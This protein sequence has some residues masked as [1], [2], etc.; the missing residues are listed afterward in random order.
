MLAKKSAFDILMNR[1]NRQKNESPQAN[2]NNATTAEKKNE[3]AT[4]TDEII[5]LVNETIILDQND[6]DI[7]VKENDTIKKNEKIVPVYHPIFFQ[8]THQYSSNLLAL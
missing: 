8:H 1:T 7:A 6:D 2:K 4:D 3:I 5:V